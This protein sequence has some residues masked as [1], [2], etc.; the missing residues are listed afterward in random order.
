MRVNFL[1]KV[2]QLVND[3]VCIGTQGNE[4]QVPALNIIVTVLH[5]V[6]EHFYLFSHLKANKQCLPHWA[7][8]VAVQWTLVFF[9][10]E[11]WDLLKLNQSEL[12]SLWGQGSILYN[13][14]NFIPCFSNWWIAPQWPRC[15]LDTELSLHRKQDGLLI[16]SDLNKFALSDWRLLKEHLPHF[17]DNRFSFTN[18][19]NYV[20]LHM[21]QPEMS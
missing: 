12:R 4:T 9:Y 5:Y 18:R 16:L 1:S 3:C 20:N 13:D 14:L 11:S 15:S 19:N 17:I 6:S 10:L 2:T 21:Y 7:V 8:E